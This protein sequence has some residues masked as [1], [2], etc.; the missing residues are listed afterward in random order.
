MVPHTPE[1]EAELS[2]IFLASDPTSGSRTPPSIRR[3]MGPMVDLSEIWSGR[4]VFDASLITAPTLIIRGDHDTFSNDPGFMDA[5]TNAPVKRYV[6]IPLATHWA[7]YEPIGA[8][9]LLGEIASFLLPSA[10][11]LGLTALNAYWAS[12]ADYES[13]LLS[14][15][16]SISNLGT[17]TA[18]D[19]LV[20]GSLATAGVSLAPTPPVTLGDLSPG[21]SGMLTLK[22][23]VPSGISRFLTTVMATAQD[24]SGIIYAYPRPP[25]A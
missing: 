2:R 14:V 24:S 15:T 7:I 20:T 6:E 5:L 21:A 16:Y 22:Y 23:V 4:P 25:A 3:A 17:A 10:P 18:Y 12:Y 11:H 9:R 13:R 8:P 1:A 19:V